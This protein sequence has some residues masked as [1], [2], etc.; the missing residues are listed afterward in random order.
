M[1]KL[2]LSISMACISLLSLAQSSEVGYNI[3]FS[4]YLGDLQPLDYTYKNPGFSTGAFFRHNV[5]SHLSFRAFFNYGR[6]SGYDSRSSIQ[7][8][9][10]RNLHFRSFIAEFG[11]DMQVNILPFDK[12]NPNNKKYKTYFNWT[13]YLFAG[14]NFFHFNPRAQYKGQWTDLQ[15]LRTEGVSYSLTQVAI[16]FGFGMKYQVHKHIVLQMEMGFRKTFFDHLD[17][18]STSY[19][20]LNKLA[21]TDPVAADMSYRGDEL[22]ENNMGMPAPG[23]QRGDSKDMD[24]YLINNVS[25]IY[26]FHHKKR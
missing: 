16:P 15:P 20:D 13:P 21:L 14:I 8:H 5:T 26:K 6:I 9:I 19:P 23:A 1:K 11:G 4:S 7:S 18:V 24:W 25:V 2:F 3:G 12:Y 22:Y 17:D 10:D